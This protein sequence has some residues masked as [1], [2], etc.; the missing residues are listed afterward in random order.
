MAKT[1]D[2]AREIMRYSSEV[3]NASGV[4]RY[5]LKYKT[6]LLADFKKIYAEFFD[7]STIR[8]IF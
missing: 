5:P 3:K 8:Y 6:E 1:T 2:E 7:L 4:M